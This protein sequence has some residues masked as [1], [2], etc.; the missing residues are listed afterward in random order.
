MSTQDMWLAIAV[1]LTFKMAAIC[2][3]WCLTIGEELKEENR[4]KVYSDDDD[5]DN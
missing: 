4:R 2:C 1:L 5:D 3:V